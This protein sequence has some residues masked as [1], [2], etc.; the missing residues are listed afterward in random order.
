[1]K[2][3]KRIKNTG[4]TAVILSIALSGISSP[5]L[6][7]FEWAERPADF[8]INKHII[9]GDENGDLMLD[10]NITREQ[11]AKMLTEAF[12]IKSKNPKLFLDVDE[13]LWSYDY[14]NRFSGLMIKTD[15]VFLPAELVT[16]EEFVTYLLIS[17]G[18]EPYAGET[19]RLLQISFSDSDDIDEDYKPYILTAVKNDF[20]KGSDMKINPKGLLTRAEACTFIYRVMNSDK[21]TSGIYI[22]TSVVPMPAATKS[23]D[24]NTGSN[25][26]NITTETGVRGEHPIMG[27]PEVTLE[28]AKKW[29]QNRG[30]H[31]RF[32]DIADLYWYYGEITGIRPEV[33]Y[34]QAAKETNF[35]KY[36]GN[37]IPEQNNWA[38]IK[39][40]DA[41][42]DTTYDHESFATPD[43]GVR[44]HFNHMGAYI[45][46]E[47][48]GEPH[49]RY[50]N[51][52]SLDW[53]GTVRYIEELGGKWAP[54]AD[55]GVSIIY[56]FI[57]PMKNTG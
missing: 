25:T 37:V 16:R 43:D 51:V 39:A 14:I 30:A 18:Y 27:S 13:N 47:P 20:L 15:I 50:Y 24:N 34:A 32:I 10:K 41:T 29:A 9:A 23:P 7:A 8:C 54:Y 19:N 4:I 31:Q 44:A 11:M 12:S 45:G 36:T 57:E 2:I 40:K 26:V 5:A 49:A 46:L 55:Y 33:M 28:Q 38:G 1:M 35:G 21:S 17:A 56:D 53:A 48:V 6:A 3:H 42:G 22:H 52:K